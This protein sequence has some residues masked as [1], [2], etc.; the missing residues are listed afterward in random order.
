MKRL[1]NDKGVSEA[2]RAKA[3]YILTGRMLPMSTITGYTT[4]KT[5]DGDIVVKSMSAQGDVV[6][7]RLF[8]NEKAAQR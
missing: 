2:T 1:M 7:S 6:T 5:E 8:T 3:Y 4:D